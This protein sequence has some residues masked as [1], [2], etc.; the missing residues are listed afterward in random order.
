MIYTRPVNII[1]A[2]MIG[3]AVILSPFYL[4]WICGGMIADRLESRR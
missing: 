3:L 1:C 2:L 4:A